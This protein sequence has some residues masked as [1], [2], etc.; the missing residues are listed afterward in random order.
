MLK[1]A[2]ARRIALYTFLVCLV[3][4]TAHA[5]DTSLLAGISTTAS[6][7]TTP[8]VFVDVVGA[9]RRTGVFTWQPTATL[10]ALRGRDVR[11]DL[12][13]D[14]VIGGAGIRLVDWW[15][16]AFFSTQI[17]YAA[18]TT[19]AISSHGQF[20]SSLGWQGDG[21]VI[22]LRHISNADAF[23]GKNLG[24]TMLLGGVTF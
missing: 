8:A 1:A 13:R 18:R 12:D 16:R 17:G 7:D 23:G 10:G 21:Y 9:E 22:M 2:P 24:E 14:V 20:I 6:N 4:P 19:A 5:L 11:V 15:R 3:S